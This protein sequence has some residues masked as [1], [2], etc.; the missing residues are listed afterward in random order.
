MS[1]EAP[2]ASAAKRR[3]P[4]PRGSFRFSRPS[5]GLLLAL[6]L[7]AALAVGTVD[8]VGIV[9]E[10]AAASGPPPRAVLDP[11]APEPAGWLQARVA[12]PWES[13]GPLPLAVN[14]YTGGLADWPATLLRLAGAPWPAVRAL[15]VALGGL[16][17]V[18]A[19]RFLRFHGPDM[20]AGAAALLL[21][22]DWCFHFYKKVLGGT[23]IL[24]QA[25]ALLLL[26]ALW[27]RRWRG[28]VH[29]TVAIAVALGLGLGAKLSF[30]AT[31]LAFG[32]A[33]L[34]TRRDRPPML[35]PASVRP[36]LLLGIVA[37]LL[38]PLAVANLHH[39]LRPELAARSHDTL[40]MQLGRLGMGGMGRETAANLLYFLQD[41][42]AS[43]APAWRCV[44]VEPLAPLRWPVFAL[45]ALGVLL[46][47]RD[48]SPSPSA[49]LLRFL[50]LAVPLQ[51]LALFLLNRDLHHLAQASVGLAL[52]CGAGCARVAGAF[53]PPRA[54]FRA[55]VSL[56]LV[57][58]AMLTGVEQLRMT[59]TVVR[60]S[61]VPLFTEAGQQA[62]VEMLRRNGVRALLTT[63]YEVYGVLEARAPE[64]AVLHG[65]PAV[66]AGR[67]DPA[68]WLALG[69]PW[70]TLRAGA[71]YIYNLR[72]RPVPGAR[73]ADALADGQDEW[74]ELWLP[75]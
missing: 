9:G 18:L 64:I 1:E 55:L 52:L 33:A 74:A 66:A 47:W 29:G 32:L 69:R 67:K 73:R 35:P 26:W 8:A 31:A 70:L 24:L 20:S 23:E 65:W 61:R 38:A 42:L 30:V 36:G 57:A 71:P 50:S 39:L 12:R 7:Y 44:A 68:A 28:G 75:E 21:A 46:A 48:R 22:T 14:S 3:P 6:A 37:L 56:V 41:P 27:S 19:H 49:A 4:P 15:H 2:R 16:L 5:L 63:D 62:L 53:A 13:L 34:L 11:T 51:V 72:P 60:T 45:A 40:A 58:P 59:D 54:A 17:L 10:I 43:L 25:S